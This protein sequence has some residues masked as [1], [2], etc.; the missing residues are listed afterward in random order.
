[1]NKQEFR[2]PSIENIFLQRGLTYQG[3][4]CKRGHPGVRYVRGGECVECQKKYNTRQYRDRVKH[5]VLAA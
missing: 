3:K 5:E 4:P 2:R 1:M